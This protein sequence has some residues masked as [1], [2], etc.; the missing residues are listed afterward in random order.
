MLSVTS[1][2][3]LI[4][5]KLHHTISMMMVLS[6]QFAFLANQLNLDRTLNQVFVVS[7]QFLVFVETEWTTDHFN[8]FLVKL[9]ARFISL[10]TA[11][12]GCFFFNIFSCLPSSF[13]YLDLLRFLGLGSGVS[14]IAVEVMSEFPPL[15]E[16]TRS[17][18]ASYSSIVIV[19]VAILSSP[20]Y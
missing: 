8:A 4:Q 14:A 1:V 11:V 15:A 17:M 7:F 3:L 9:C 19:I 6:L 18:S 2:K 10:V 5:K 16:R 20:G 13:E 12:R